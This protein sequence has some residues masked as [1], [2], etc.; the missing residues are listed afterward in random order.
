[1]SK[2]RPVVPLRLDPGLIEDM[3]I[4]IIRRNENTRETP[5]SFSDFIRVAICEKLH[6]MKRGRKEQGGVIHPTDYGHETG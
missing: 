2:G 6:K 4:A 5:W 3:E 1:M